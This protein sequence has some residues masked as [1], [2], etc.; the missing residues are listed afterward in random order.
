MDW[1]LDDMI[2]RHVIERNAL[3]SWMIALTLSTVMA[4]PVTFCEDGVKGRPLADVAVQ[5]S[6]T[7][8]ELLAG[9]VKHCCWQECLP[10]PPSL[11]SHC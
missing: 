2:N 1:K 10:H 9:K 7:I 11:S 6:A 5:N 4:F 8:L 3:H